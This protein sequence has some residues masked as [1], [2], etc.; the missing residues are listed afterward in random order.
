MKFMSDPPPSSETSALQTKETEGCLDEAL[1]G[2][3]RVF[4]FP[5]NE[6]IRIL[7]RVDCMTRRI[8]YF[9]EKQS[10]FEH[11]S[12]LHA[13]FELYELLS[14]R[15]D[16]KNE[17]LQ[18]LDRQRAQLNRFIDQPGVSN[19][20]LH[21]VL[22]EISVAHANL[23]EVPVRLGPHLAE[24]EFLQG[25]KG[26]VGIPAGSCPFDLPSYFVWLHRPVAIR[27][28]SLDAWVAPLAPLMDATALCLRILRDGAEP[29]N[30]Q[31]NQGVFELNPEGRLARLIRVRIPREPELVCEV[32][33]NKYVVAVRFRALDEQLRP[34]AI[35]TRVEFELT[36]CDF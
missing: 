24:F 22:S 23:T 20:R 12:C 33:A 7:M 36:L 9:S 15:G 11:E 13:L 8:R 6:R 1:N 26:R 30:Y 28:A 17:L 34:K 2:S 29:A 14:S 3:D 25:L 16:I 5:C 35:E 31:A 32:S 18:E 4:E 21:E 27:K 10:Q 19:D